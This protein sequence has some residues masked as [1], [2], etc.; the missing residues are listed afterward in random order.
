[1]HLEQGPPGQRERQIRMA[2]PQPRPAREEIISQRKSGSNCTDK[3][4]IGHSMGVMGVLQRIPIRG[5]ERAEMTS[6][7]KVARVKPHEIDARDANPARQTHTTGKSNENHAKRDQAHAEQTT[8]RHMTLSDPHAQKVAQGFRDQFPSLCT[9][10]TDTPPMN[11]MTRRRILQATRWYAMQVLNMVGPTNKL[12]RCK[13][14]LERFKRRTT[15][16]NA[17]RCLPCL[18]A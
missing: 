5:S 14:R 15:F 18:D 9:I 13:R 11:P 17:E 4:Y 8:R 2:S 16:A 1:M 6:L 12:A 3:R 7:S 10:D